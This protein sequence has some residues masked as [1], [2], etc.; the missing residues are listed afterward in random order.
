MSS[1][2]LVY[3][4]Q[5][6]K[7]LI[8]NTPL[9]TDLYPEIVDK[10]FTASK[11]INYNSGETIVNEGDLGNSLFIILRG[12][13]NVRKNLD[14]RQHTIAVLNEGDIFGEIALMINQPRTA[15]VV[16]AE[17]SELLQVFRRSLEPI[18]KEHPSLLIRLNKMMAD[19]ISILEDS[20]TD[21]GKQK[22]RPDIRPDLNP[23]LLELLMNLNEKIGGE[24]QAEHSK[25]VAMLARE[26]AKILCP[27]LQE[28]LFYAGYMHEIGKMGIP[29][30]LIKKE[31]EGKQQ[32]TPQETSYF[33]D[34]YSSA[35]DILAPDANMA[36]SVSF[37]EYLSKNAY[38]E[39]PIEAQI[40][41]TADDYLMMVSANYKNI[42]PEQAIEKIKRLSGKRYNPQVVTA[43]EKV[44]E[45]FQSLKVEKQLEFL[46]QMNIALD[47]KD[48]YTL[49]HSIHTRDTS[50]KIARYINGKYINGKLIEFSENDLTLLKYSCELHDVGKIQVPTEILI[51]PR[52]LTPDEM[53]IMR[54]HADFSSKFFK[55]IPGMGALTSAVRHHHEKYDGNGYP[56]GLK[57]E[58]IP[59]MSRIM[60]IADVFSALTTKRSYRVDQDGEKLGFSS[61]KAI[62]IM[63]EMEGHFD[64]GLFEIFKIIISE[65]EN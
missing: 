21:H 11:H 61:S 38:L 23:S 55:D 42:K 27:M 9:F 1:L 39:T 62:E 12:S 64:P 15:T 26:M 19:R 6:I 14:G 29:E 52:K 63:N 47:F 32:L 28:Q 33:T 41:M 53:A 31:R 46:Q 36:K 18:M 65:E 4:P 57:G 56:D 60:S 24:E 20:E 13:V 54:K 35:V 59:L 16:A 34:I 7:S 17:N 44:I 5:D 50:L 43:F 10:I 48:H 30:E 49:S 37:V 45:K 2:K 3:T 25:E 8:Q 58:E 51:A 40:L 22:L